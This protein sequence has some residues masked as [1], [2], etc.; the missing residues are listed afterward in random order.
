MAL[1]G[2]YALIE[3][4]VG[5]ARLWHER[6]LLEWIAGDEYVVC[7]PDRDIFV[8]ELSLVNSDI[9]TMRL[10]PAANVVPGGVVAAEIYGLPAWGPNELQTIRDEARQVAAAERARRGGAVAGGVGGAVAAPV[11]VGALATPHTTGQLRWLAAET[12]GDYAYG[13]EVDGVAAVLAR[14]AKSIHTLAGGTLL[15][16]ECVDGADVEEF[17]SRPGQNDFRTLKISHNVMGE[18]EITL[19]DLS[20]RCKEVPVKWVLPGPRT[21]K[22]CI[23]YLSIEG[24]GLEGHHE[25]FRQICKIDSSA[26][27]V[28][29]HFQVTMAVRQALLVDQLDGC[30]LL[31]IEVQFRR[32]QTIEFSYAER[33][34]EAESRAVGGK[35]SLEEQ[36]SFG[37][38]TRQFSTLMICPQLLE[39]VKSE[40]EREASLAKNLRKAREERE[41]TRKAA[42][43]KK[44]GPNQG[45]GDP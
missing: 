36:T 28:Q 35:L 11:P 45:E 14:G 31:S 12:L 21:S 43:K 18:P 27:G 44:P 37:G 19:K 25:R 32:L 23:S 22:W 39:H 40:T 5:G 24:L 17:L 34:R 8:E 6:W 13:A 42:A 38:M 2:R 15:F 16:V 20:M 3:Y 33:A 30:N 4:D 9:R 10:R 26:W 41:A 29:E 7:T 1:V